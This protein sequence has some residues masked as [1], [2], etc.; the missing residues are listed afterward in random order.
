MAFA[1][2]L[3]METVAYLLSDAIVQVP[4]VMLS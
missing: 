1:M 4:P 3:G 2:P